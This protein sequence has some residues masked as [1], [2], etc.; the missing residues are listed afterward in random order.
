MKVIG[1]IGKNGSGKDEVLKYLRDKHGVPFLSTG[2]M[3]RAIAAREG[4]ELTRE[5]LG[6]ISERY[7]RQYGKGCFVRLVV[8]EI[9]KNGWRTA[10]ISGIRSPDDVS[11]LKE[12]CGSDFVLVNVEVSDDRQRFLRMGKRGEGR[13][14]HSY[15]QFLS[16][17]Q[18]EEQRFH[19]SEA[20]RLAHF[21][22]NNDGT[23]ADLHRGVETLVERGLL[24]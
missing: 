22:L 1:V 16:Q 18:A 9:K 13:D 21:S 7:F 5:N 12:M 6:E 24:K 11:L 14:P 17:E 3:V 2:E 8:E 10:G 23:L 19:V 15:E 4:K 20:A